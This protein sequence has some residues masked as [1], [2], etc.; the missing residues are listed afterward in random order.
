M[1]SE[2]EGFGEEDLDKDRRPADSLDMARSKAPGLL[3]SLV[4]VVLGDPLR[5]VGE[6]AL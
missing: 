3:E 2:L 6:E 5:L 4:V 1:S